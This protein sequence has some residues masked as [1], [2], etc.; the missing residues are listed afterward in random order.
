M[1]TSCHKFI[2]VYGSAKIVKI[3]YDLSNLLTE[4]Y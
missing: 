3:G 1:T 2:F 4:V